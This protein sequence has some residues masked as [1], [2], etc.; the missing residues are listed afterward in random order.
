VLE[1][2]RASDARLIVKSAL[3][4][5]LGEADED[6]LASLR[7]LRAVGV[8]W[9]T[10]G[11]YL[12]PTRKHVPVRRFVPPEAFD[13]LA[14]EARALGFPLVSAGPLVRSSYRAAEEHAKF[15]VASRR[16]GVMPG[17]S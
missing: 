9:V 3:L 17:R 16:E 12:R 5:G 6:V 13:R 7:D 4:L 15:L 1:A 11:Q 10:L 2:L 8:D 14:A